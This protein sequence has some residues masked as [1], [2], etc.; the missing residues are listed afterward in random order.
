MHPDKIRAVGVFSV[1]QCSIIAF[2]LGVGMKILRQHF[3][4]RLK[5]KMKIMNSSL[6]QMLLSL[7]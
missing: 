3:D 7:H 2:Q 1:A 5:S 4:A 6:L